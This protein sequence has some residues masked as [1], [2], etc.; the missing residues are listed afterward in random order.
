MTIDKGGP[1]REN[2][3]IYSQIV[4]DGLYEVYIR[5]LLRGYY[6]MYAARKR[7]NHIIFQQEIDIIHPATWIDKLFGIRSAVDMAKK[8]LKK[9]KHDRYCV[10]IQQAYDAEL[11]S[12]LDK[13]LDTTKE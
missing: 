5:E 1:S 12:E 8:A 3:K 6:V 10:Q 4:L 11:R 13:I 9:C 7:D 2:D